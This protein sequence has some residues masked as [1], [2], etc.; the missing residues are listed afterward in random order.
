VGSTSVSAGDVEADVIT[1]A[2]SQMFAVMSDDPTDEEMFAEQMNL[3][4]IWSDTKAGSDCERFAAAL[5]SVSF[6][7]TARLIAENDPVT[8]GTAYAQ[9]LHAAF[10][11]QFVITDE[12]G[13]LGNACRDER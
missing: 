5:V 13:R 10:Q 8:E 9:T 2:G 6:V 7:T 3:T 1:E 11:G 4:D 12:L